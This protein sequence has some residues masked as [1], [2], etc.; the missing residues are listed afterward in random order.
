MGIKKFILSN[1]NVERNSYIWNLTG[2]ML[3]AFQSVIM[4]MI[5]MRTLSVV[6]AGIFTIAYAN[7]N[8]FLTI[9]KYGMRN[10]QVS[11]LNNQ[12]SFREYRA[13]RI[14]T[15]VVMIVVSIANIMYNSI[16]YEYSAYKS[17]IIMC[18][19]LFKVVDAAE[20]IYN[21]LYQKMR[22]LDMS[23]R[24]M[25]IR[26][27]ATILV[28]GI[29][30]IVFKN[31]LYALI[32]STLFTTV[33]LIV[34]ISWTYKPYEKEAGDL[35][36]KNVTELLMSCFPLFLGSFLSFYIG[37]AP[38][39]AIDSLL[40]D[41]L[42]ACYGFISMPVFVIG[43]LNGFIFNP[44]LYYVSS[45]WKERK[46]S[47]FFKR[48]FIQI[49]IIIGITGICIMGA[50]FWGIPVLSAL[51]AIDLSGFRKELLILLLGGG[52]LAMSGFLNALITIIRFQKIII[53]GYG[54]VAV[55]A[56]LLSGY[57]VANYQIMGAAILYTILMGILCVCF[58]GMFLAGVIKRNSEFRNK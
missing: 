26:L 21:G 9:G 48:V 29:G 43:L 51:Y 46:M 12:F 24:S 55:V 38:K 54:V 32:I 13:S 52:F 37:S 19:C 14:F 57:M 17:L 4:L 45:L 34:L 15:A 23:S 40:T 22:R 42:Q 30:I 10:F 49:G 31:L 18:M 44:I 1:D 7:A 47:L 3:M 2:S 8:L 6:D 33:F 5:L 36:N 27:F 56:Y 16:H 39:Y 20:D 11:D 41:D 35:K 53:L 58:V 50:Y 28:F 25:T